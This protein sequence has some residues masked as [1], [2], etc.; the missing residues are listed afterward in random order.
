MSIPKTPIEFDYDLW[1]T[2]DGRCMVRVKATGEITEVER[3]VMQ[4]L[5]SEEKRL[6][7]AISPEQGEHRD[8]MSK[9]T[10]LSLDVLPEDVG[11]SSWLADTVD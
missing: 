10:I 8:G 6:R 7:R 5:R 1:T 9:P 2:E 3:S 4:A 11:D